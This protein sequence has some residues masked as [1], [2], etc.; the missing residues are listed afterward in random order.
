MIL[1][2]DLACMTILAYADFI[3]GTRSRQN[4]GNG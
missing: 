2:D 3:V 4:P 1:V